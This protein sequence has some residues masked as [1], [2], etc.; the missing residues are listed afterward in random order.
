MVNLTR[1]YTRVGDDGQTRLVDGSSVAKSD[2]R[3]VV[4]GDIDELNSLLG[5]ALTLTPTADVGQVLVVLQNQLFDLGAD[6][7]TPLVDDDSASPRIPAAAIAQLET[8]CDQFNASLPSQRSFV[9]P[10]GTP[11]AAQLHWA[12]TVARRAERTAW[13]LADQVPVNRL[14]IRYLNRLSDLLFIMARH[15]NRQA[16]VPEVLWTAVAY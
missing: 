10:G 13:A 3:L 4:C 16:S 9:L 7:A 8:W 5:I 15:V 2:I 12:R 6:M 11:L 14:G 1:I